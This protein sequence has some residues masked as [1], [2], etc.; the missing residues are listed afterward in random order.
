MPVS[1]LPV[2]TGLG[3]WIYGAVAL[4]LGAVFLA[5]A[6]RL[7]RSTAGDAEAQGADMKLAKTTFVFSIF[8]LFALFAAV[9]V[10]HGAGLHFPLMGG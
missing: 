10:E 4:G 5:Y 1:L 3:G 7:V 9:M 6:V 2:A 8:Y